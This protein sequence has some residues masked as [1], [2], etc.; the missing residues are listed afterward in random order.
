M[1][2]FSQGPNWWQASD[3]KWYPPE[4]HPNHQLTLPPPPVQSN[5]GYWQASDG[6]WYP[7]ELAHTD[8]QV[9]SRRNSAQSIKVPNLGDL[10]KSR[11]SVLI[12]AIVIAALILGVMLPWASGSFAGVTLSVEG[13]STGDGKLFLALVVVVAALGYWSVIDYRRK[14]LAI[15]FAGSTALLV[16]EC[17]YE[18]VHW[19][20]SSQ[21]GIGFY[22]DTLGSI[23]AS[24]SAINILREQ[25]SS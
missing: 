22:L 24:L 8:T 21:F 10:L 19:G 14:Q 20:S 4:Q 9:Y 17:V 11:K 13:I 3:G 5:P 23:A 25:L 2:D 1:S 15:I 12:F 7:P 18:F 16:A 6:N